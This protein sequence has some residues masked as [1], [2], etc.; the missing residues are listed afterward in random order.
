MGR[1]GLDMR[2]GVIS[3]IGRWGNTKARASASVS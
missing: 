2:D 1:I 3:G